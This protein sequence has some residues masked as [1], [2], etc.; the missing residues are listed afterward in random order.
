MRDSVR[1]RPASLRRARHLRRRGRGACGDDRLEEL[2]DLVAA[3]VRETR[4]A[5]L[6]VVHDL[7]LA[8]QY[9]DRLL[10]L[11][12]G[13]PIALGGIAE[14]MT[15][16]RIRETFGVD[17]YVG[18]NELTGARYF[19]PMRGCAAPLATGTEAVSAASASTAASEP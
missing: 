3:R 12:G 5:A 15:Y 8:A 4:A 16:R 18:V 1:L 9:C 17:V 7:N 14:V 19:V 2:H 11:R 6:L 13:A 10:L